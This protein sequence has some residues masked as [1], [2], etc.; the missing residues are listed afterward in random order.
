MLACTCLASESPAWLERKLNH[1]G[2]RERERTGAPSVMMASDTLFQRKY[3]IPFLLALA[4]L[5]L[6]KLIGFGCVVPYA[7]VLFQKAGL[8][9]AWGNAGDCAIKALNLA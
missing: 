9:G 7:V 5:T 1:N 6:N 2:A 8:A 3:V 4:V